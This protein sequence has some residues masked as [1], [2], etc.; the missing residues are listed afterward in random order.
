[1]QLE[2]VHS[3]QDLIAELRE[4][5][6]LARIQPGTDRVFLEHRS[7][8]E[9][10]TDVAQEVD[11]A[12]RR[13]PIEV[14]DHDETIRPLGAQVPRDLS[15]EGTDPLGHGVFGV[16]HALGSGARI[17]DEPGGSADQPEWAVACELDAAK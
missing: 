12:E 2:E 7:D 3:L 9:M 10:L 17:A 4:T 16:Q 13:R 15:L 5:D 11:G 14:V 8:A 1:M 6:A